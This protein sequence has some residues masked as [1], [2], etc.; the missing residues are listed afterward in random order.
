MPGTSFTRSNLRQKVN[1]LKES[2]NETAKCKGKIAITQSPTNNRA[3]GG[4]HPYPSL[5]LTK[6]GNGSG[7]EVWSRRYVELGDCPLP[8]VP[9]G[10][11]GD[12]SICRVGQC[13]RTLG[14]RAAYC[15]NVLELSGKCSALP[16]RTLAAEMCLTWG[17]LGMGVGTTWHWG[18]G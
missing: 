7:A 10:L 18:A 17:W 1:I 8:T 16:A 13:W 4:V 14:A 6:Q 15:K 5:L 9:P 2:K 12:T 11:Q 3:H